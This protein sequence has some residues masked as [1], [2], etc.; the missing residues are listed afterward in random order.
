M[1][2]LLARFPSGLV[3]LEHYDAS[4]TFGALIVPTRARPAADEPLVV[5]VS[6][7]ELSGRVLLRGRADGAAPEGAPRLH[8]R[9]LPSERTKRDY[10]L[11]AARGEVRGDRARRHRRF[12]LRVSVRFC[13][14]DGGGCTE[15]VTEDLSTAGLFIRTPFLLPMRT[16]VTVELMPGSK[17]PLAV[18][19]HVAWQR[20]GAPSSGFGVSLDAE[21][22]REARAL[23][24]LV[25]ALKS[26]GALDEG[27]REDTGALPMLA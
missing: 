2:I 4:A 14:S 18:H 13:E 15:A 23:R 9:L 6:F 22:R 21:G 16:P 17:V 1:R 11:A 26:S 25:R 5:E 19:G 7:P 10:M 8:V 20:T 12:P 3:L 27:A 24:R